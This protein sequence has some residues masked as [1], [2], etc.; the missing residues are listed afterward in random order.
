MKTLRLL[1]CL[2]L[3]CALTGRAGDN[4]APGP[5]I[6]L[7]AIDFPLLM[8]HRGITTGEVHLM[9]KIGPDAQLLDALVTAYTHKAFA[10]ATL[11]ALPRST[12]RP[13]RLDGEPVTTLARLVVRFEVNG[14]L[15]VALQPDTFAYGPCAPDRLDQPLQAVATP[16]PGY[17]DDLRQQGVQG[18]VVIEYYVDENG[19][20]RMPAVSRAENETLAGLT[21]QAVEQ[22][23]F[24]PPSSHG[25]P[26]LVRVRQKFAFVPGQ[27][28]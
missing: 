23:R 16:S 15:Y 4:P 6:T 22:W 18:T 3:A 26:A 1:P 12:L 21:L 2:A 17:P 27:A 8:L 28:G 10:D 24:N 19:R 9:V 5:A 11:A 20:V 7:P 14:T 25:K 13:Q